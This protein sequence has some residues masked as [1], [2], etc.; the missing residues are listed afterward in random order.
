[1]RFH[2]GVTDAEYAALLA[3]RAVLVSAS[4]DEGYGLPVA[5]ALA[6]GC[7]AVVTD[8]PIFREVAG[9]GALYAPGVDAAAFAAAVRELDDP[10]RRDAVIAAGSAHIARF[11]WR[12]RPTCC[13]TRSTA[14]APALT[15]HHGRREG[16][17]GTAGDVRR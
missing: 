4:L 2:G 6:L 3:E 7:P 14:S 5:E 10:E 17:V 9:D 16:S 1:V 11:S 13:S 8:M 15:R 12:A